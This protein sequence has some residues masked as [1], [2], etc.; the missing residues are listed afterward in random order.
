MADQLSRQ[1]AGAT[2]AQVAERFRYASR[3]EDYDATPHD[4]SSDSNWTADVA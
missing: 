4:S 3:D 1:S 2:P